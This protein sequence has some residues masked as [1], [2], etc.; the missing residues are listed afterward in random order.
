MGDIVYIVLKCTH[1]MF[2]CC[3][4]PTAM[5]I[6][7][8]V[9]AQAPEANATI[10]GVQQSFISMGQA[11]GPI[12]GSLLLKVSLY[13]PFAYLVSFEIAA[14]LLNLLVFVRARRSGG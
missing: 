12:L 10:M 4:S 9:A 1:F 13:A 3:V 2:Q 5:A 7:A 11:V 6:A 14:L 8:S